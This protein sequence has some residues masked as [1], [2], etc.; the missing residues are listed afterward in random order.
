[1]VQFKWFDLVGHFTLYGIWAYFFGRAFTKTIFKIRQFSLSA[2]IAI[3][4]SIAIIEESL[5]VVSPY[6]SFTLSDMAFSLLGI[7]TAALYLN[8][9]RVKKV[10]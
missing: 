1:M 6:R 4:A 7:L 5:Q 3:C 10:I 9:F 8:S 2:G